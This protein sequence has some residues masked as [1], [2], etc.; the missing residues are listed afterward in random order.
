MLSSVLYYLLLL[1]ILQKTSSIRG[2]PSIRG[3]LPK[4]LCAA[5]LEV[6]EEISAVFQGRQLK[7]N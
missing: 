4:I 7:H 5:K 3:N 1:C 2:N 6:L